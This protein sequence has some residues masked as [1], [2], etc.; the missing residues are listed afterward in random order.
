MPAFTKERTVP[1][2]I[3]TKIITT[4]HQQLAPVKPEAQGYML[5]TAGNTD[6]KWHTFQ[7]EFAE[8]G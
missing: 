6:P 4:I 2:A 3:K 8:E 5:I 7:L 1:H